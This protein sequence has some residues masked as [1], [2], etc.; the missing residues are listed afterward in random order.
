MTKPISKEYRIYLALWRK[1]YR[2]ELNQAIKCP[3]L[4]M[5]VAM[6]QGMY[7]A[8]KPF[9]EAESGDDEL[10]KA[11]ERFVVYLI[12]GERADTFHF[13]EFRERKTLSILESSWDELGLSDDDLLIGEE[14]SISDKLKELLDGAEVK[15]RA[16]P[17]F[18]RDS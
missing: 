5:A 15:P 9:R 14:R 16:T 1:A 3:N 8:I 11:S 12:K 13:L 6:R 4:H 7:R 10:R 2:G 17:F 18:T